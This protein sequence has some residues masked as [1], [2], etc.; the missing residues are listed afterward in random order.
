MVENWQKDLVEVLKWLFGA[1]GGAKV[2]EIAYNGWKDHRLKNLIRK[3]LYEELA[4]NYE[5]V[6]SRVAISS[7]LEGLRQGTS[8]RF[9]DK[10]DIRFQ[11]QNQHIELDKKLFWSI[12]EAHTLDSLY[13][14]FNLIVLE[15]DP[16]RART[17]SIE[18]AAA[19][20]RAAKDGKL[21]KALLKDVCTPHLLEVPH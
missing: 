6:V 9:N 1:I 7:S 12:N 15:M 16:Y 11:M 3:H 14:K 4:S 8:N 19:F 5:S 10:L 20:E 21:D 2:F 17:F 13:N 18:A